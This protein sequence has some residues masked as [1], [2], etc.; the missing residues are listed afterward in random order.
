MKIV[1][2]QEIAPAANFNSMT[3]TTSCNRWPIVGKNSS[4]L[5]LDTFFIQIKIINYNKQ[6]HTQINSIRD[7]HRKTAKQT[8]GS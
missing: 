7:S 3:I 4:N 5:E 6:V 2:I 1:K 8:R